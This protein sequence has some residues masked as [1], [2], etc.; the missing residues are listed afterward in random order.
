MER[1]NIKTQ[2]RVKAL[3]AVTRSFIGLD[4]YDLES[5][6]G[7]FLKWLSQ[8]LD[9]TET[10]ATNHEIATFHSRSVDDDIPF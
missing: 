3:E 10:P 9:Q 7:N 5:K 8:D 1:M 4:S 2:L 6:A